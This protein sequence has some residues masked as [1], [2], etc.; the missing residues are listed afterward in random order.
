M[1]LYFA[2]RVFYLFSR[3]IDQITIFFKLKLCI[4]LFIVGYKTVVFFLSLRFVS[5]CKRKYSTGEPMNDETC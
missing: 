3:F 2:K 1:H 4:L 5:F